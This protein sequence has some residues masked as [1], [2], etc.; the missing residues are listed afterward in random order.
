MAELHTYRNYIHTCTYVRNK[1]VI[2]A[3]ERLT[4]SK[5]ISNGDYGR[6]PSLEVCARGRADF[7]LQFFFL[8]MWM[9]P[10]C[11]CLRRGK[12]GS[13]C[14]SRK[15]LVLCDRLQREFL[16]ARSMPKEHVEPVITQKYCYWPLRIW[17]GLAGGRICL[18]NLPFASEICL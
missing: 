8:R 14:T 15:L 4:D 17:L 13:N 12:T 5:H 7:S 18:R 1:H 16:R 9:L 10:E 3:A 2:T 6:T 11:L